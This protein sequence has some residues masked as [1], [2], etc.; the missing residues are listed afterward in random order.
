MMQ[1]PI[2]YS[3]PMI[4][5]IM[6]CAK[7]G[8]ISVPF[9]C[10]Y[11]GSTE[12]VKNQ[13]RRAMKPQPWY[14]GQAIWRWGPLSLAYESDWIRYCPYGGP[15]DLLWPRETWAH[16]P[17]NITTAP[18]IYYRADYE[19]GELPGSRVQDIWQCDHHWRP[20]IHMPK[21]ACRLWLGI[22]EVR[23]QRLQE[24]SYDDCIAEGIDLCNS[25]VG[26]IVREQYELLWD[27]LNAKAKP[28]K[29]NPYTL[30]REDCYVSY[31]WPDVRRTGIY[32][33]K[34][35]YIVGNPWVWALSFQRTVKP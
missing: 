27:F 17:Q 23:V 16:A 11:C 22:S 15:G 3:T 9:P 21:E 26:W 20:S 7:C 24:I 34:A 5:M 1:H 25:S 32:R 14:N 12:F 31:P 33:G 28:A 10:K 2:L 29:H 4:R 6:T 30:A 35:H 13:T 19:S 18:H 8:K